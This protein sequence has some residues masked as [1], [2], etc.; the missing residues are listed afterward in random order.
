MPK[1]GH[2]SKKKLEILSKF[3]SLPA[4]RSDNSYDIT[5]LQSIYFEVF[6]CVR[7]YQIFIGLRHFREVE[8]TSYESPRGSERVKREEVRFSREVEGITKVCHPVRS[9]PTR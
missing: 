8:V 5:V 1:D 4:I 9:R 3:S 7:S 6:F 2:K